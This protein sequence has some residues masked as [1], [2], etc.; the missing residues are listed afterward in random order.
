MAES[1]HKKKLLL[2]KKLADD[3]ESSKLIQE[4]NIKSAKNAAKK[5]N[6][7]KLLKPTTQTQTQS[8]YQDDAD[9]MPFIEDSVTAEVAGPQ[10][11]LNKSNLTFFEK[12]GNVCKD[13]VILT[14]N[15]TT[16]IYY[17]WKRIEP[18]AFFTSTLLDK[19]ER[20]FSHAVPVG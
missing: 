10:L 1:K 13:Y 4:Y 5:I 12:T 15:G 9:T 6:A 14:N 18:I 8:S 19:E 17:K 16:A 11:R 7:S 20:F 2:K 3:M